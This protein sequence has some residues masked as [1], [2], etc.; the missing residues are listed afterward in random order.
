MPGSHGRKWN[1]FAQHPL[2]RGTSLLLLHGCWLDA[3][4]PMPS[5]ALPYGGGHVIHALLLA[6][7]PGALWACDHGQNNRSDP[8]NVSASVRVTMKAQTE[9]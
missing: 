1:V 7:E 5:P 9:Q 2:L 8:W 4:V 3:P 6:V